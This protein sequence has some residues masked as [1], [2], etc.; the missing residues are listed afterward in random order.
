MA[1]AAVLSVVHRRHEDTSTA[2]L[3]RAFTSETLDLAIAINLVVLEHGQFGLLALVLDFLGSRVHLLLPLLRA[4]TETK[5]KV[6]GRF[7]LDV[8]VG[9]STAVFQLLAG[10]DQALLVRWNAF[11]VCVN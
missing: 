1:F 6:E 7:L 11:L 2:L 5:D 3:G 10:E 8:V 9:E 4:T